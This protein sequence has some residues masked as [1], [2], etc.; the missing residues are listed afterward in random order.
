LGRTGR[1]TAERHG[2]RFAF[3]FAATFGS[4]LLTGLLAQQVIA[5]LPVLPALVVLGAIVALGVVSDGIG[6]AVT[7]AHEPPFRAMAAR[8]LPG[9][10]HSLYLLRNA[11][12]V[13]SLC[14]DVIG[15]IASTVSGAAAIALLLVVTGRQ[16]GGDG[17]SG[18]MVVAGVAALTVTGKAWGKRFAIRDAN[19]VIRHL[20]LALYWGGKVIRPRRVVPG[21]RGREKGSLG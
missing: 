19:T 6:V 13:A 14:S 15:D 17:L 21:Q 16:A 4:A 9:A 18:F 5:E 10:R 11:D 3:L 1:S 2:R 20:G 12:R 7:R 8:R